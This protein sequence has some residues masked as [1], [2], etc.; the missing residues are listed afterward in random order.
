MLPNY[1]SEFQQ[2]V[3]DDYTGLASFV[4]CYKE[5]LSGSILLT[6]MV[7]SGECVSYA[8]AMAKT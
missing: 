7:I 3:L 4:H 8:S 5:R 1:S 6:L 2:L